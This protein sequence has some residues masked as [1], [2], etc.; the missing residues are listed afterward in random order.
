[1]EITPEQAKRILRTLYK[2]EDKESALLLGPIGIGKSELI[3][4]FA[5]ETAKE[6]KKEFIDYSDDNLNKILESPEKYFV[7]VDIRLTEIEPSDLIGIPRDSNEHVIYKPLGWGR[8][9]SKAAGVL[10]LDEITN[11]Q[12]LDVQAAMY[13][14]LLDRKVG[15]IKLN[16]NVLVAAAGNRP[17]DS[18]IANML[19][20][21]AIN[22]VRRFKIRS[23]TLDEWIEYMNRY[24]SWDR[25]VAGFLKR[26]SQYLIS[27]RVDQETLEQF[28]SPRKWTHLAL[29]SENLDLEDLEVISDAEVG[30]EAAAH[31]MAFVKTKIPDL[32][33]II[34][35]PELYNNL[36]EEQKY[37]CVVQMSSKIFNE[38]KENKFDAK[39]Y[40]KFLGNLYKRDR[41]GLTLMAFLMPFKERS[42]LVK[43]IDETGMEKIVDFFFDLYTK[44]KAIE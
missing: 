14:L 34:K 3:R 44:Q 23:P 22:R 37:F 33:K 21:P 38:I 13:K 2:K 36:E 8:A 43:F 39:K 25:R 29:V 4:Q 5:E 17:E 7:F 28:P 1:M 35:K 9:L 12:R 31:F 41:E 42:K 18:T 32:N 30:P 10:F 15:F 19:P 16:R 26:F 6:L 24:D 27:Q 40:R 20:A 11:V